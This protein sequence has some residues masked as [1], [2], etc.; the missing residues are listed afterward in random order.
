MSKTDKGKGQE[1]AKVEPHGDNK[2][3]ES[4]GAIEQLCRMTFE[5]IIK[6]RSN[7]D[8]VENQRRILEE[9]MK[10]ERANAIQTEVITSHKKNVEID[11]KWQ[12]LEEQENCEEL[13]EEIEE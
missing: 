4:R 13:A 8:A 9:K 10:K 12:E 1:R 2:I 3:S 7:A 5:T 6:I 11:W